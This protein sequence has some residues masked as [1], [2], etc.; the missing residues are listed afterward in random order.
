MANFVLK[1]LENVRD[2]AQAGVLMEV[3]AE[4]HKQIQGFKAKITHLEKMIEE[5]SADGVAVAV[6]RDIAKLENLQ[7]ELVGESSKQKVKERANDAMWLIISGIAAIVGYELPSEFRYLEEMP[8]F[9]SA[10]ILILIVV[11]VY[12]ATKKPDKKT[13][14]IE[15]ARKTSAQEI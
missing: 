4:S 7:V 8:P 3:Y 6:E 15:K 10:F 11:V 5:L 12:A 9:M 1:T 13:Q 2:I 14:R